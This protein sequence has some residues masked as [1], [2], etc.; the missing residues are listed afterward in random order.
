MT[1][2]LFIDLPQEMKFEGIFRDC[3]MAGLCLNVFGVNYFHN[4]VEKWIEMK[5]G[6]LGSQYQV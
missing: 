3:H 4:S 1:L 5:L 6:T 2:V